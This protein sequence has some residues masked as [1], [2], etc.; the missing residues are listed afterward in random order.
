MR[1]STEESTYEPIA[2]VGISGAFPQS[3][4]ANQLWQ[5]II[6]G[7]NC[8]T[9]IPDSRWNWREYYGDPMNQHNKTKIKWG[10]FIE[11]VDQFDPLFFEISPR[12]AE[13]MDLSSDFC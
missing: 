2:I 13:L 4:D 8:I 9:E 1:K 10:G 5:N 7:R 11:G 6:E 12:E 3:E